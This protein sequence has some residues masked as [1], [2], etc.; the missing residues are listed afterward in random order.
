MTAPPGSSPP[1]TAPPGIALAIETAA[2]DVSLALLDLSGD[3][4]R[5]LAELAWRTDR[6]LSEQ[7]LAAIDALLDEAEV[8]RERIASVAVDVGPG[9]YTGLRIGVATAQGLALGLGV[10]LAGVGRL[11]ATAWPHLVSS[12]RSPEGRP[13]VAV[14]DAGRGRIAWAAYTAGEASPPSSAPPVTIEAPRQDDAA[15]CARDAPPGAL[16]CGELSGE[17][18]DALR[19]ARDAAG[20]SGDT[21]AVPVRGRPASDLVRLA[22]VHEAYGDPALVDVLYRRPGA[23]G[24]A[25]PAAAADHAAAKEDEAD[26]VGEVER[27]SA[28]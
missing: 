9:G 22:R 1:G 21:E 18:G 19:T 3:G 24:R 10:P 2:N 16:W 5:L 4:E 27:W 15:T 26:R 7:L 13:V 25:L 20:R 8:E 12:E 14:H 28:R 17:A 6:A 23:G 11:E